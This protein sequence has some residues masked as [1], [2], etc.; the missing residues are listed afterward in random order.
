MYLTP[1]VLLFFQFG[2]RQ[3][4]FLF[5]CL[6]NLV[7][8]KMQDIES[9]IY[10]LSSIARPEQLLDNPSPLSS[11]NNKLSDEHLILALNP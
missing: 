1:T 3:Q 10:T 8:H 6:L 11:Q 5:S 9:A 7:V 4:K 2:T